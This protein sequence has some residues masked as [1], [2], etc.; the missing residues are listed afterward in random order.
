MGNSIINKEDALQGRLSSTHY[1]QTLLEALYTN[2]ILGDDDMQRIQLGLMNILNETIGYYTKD[3]SSSIREETAAQ[4]TASI[5]YT[6]GL[7]LKTQPDLKQAS[8][9]LQ[10]E[11]MKDLFAQGEEILRSKVRECR[12]LL[13]KAIQSRLK[14]GNLAYTDTLNYGIPLFF[15]EYDMRFASHETPGSIDY[16]LAIIKQDLAGVEYIEDYLNGLLLENEFCSFFEDKEIEA[17][18]RGYA[19]DSDLLLIN[20]FRLVLTNFLGYILAGKVGNSLEINEAERRDIKRQLDNLSDAEFEDIMK[21][22][23]E[24]IFQQL[25]IEDKDLKGYIDRTVGMITKEIRRHIERDTLKNLFITLKWPDSKRVKFEDG[26]SLKDSFFR[27]IT[28][29]IRD[30]SSVEDKIEIIKQELHSMR[31]LIDVFEADCIFADQFDDIFS[32]LGDFEI[33]LLM[34]HVSS[35][36]DW[37]NEDEENE[38]EWQT[39]FRMYFDTLGEERRNQIIRISEEIEI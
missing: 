16:P 17:L 26:E 27:D 29:E 15:K 3:E 14:T 32:V 34:K 2:N 38:K 6:I 39:E 12:M 9:M 5:Y 11:D 21:T 8:S 18:L 37:D 30:C 10:E 19:K 20:V 23:K 31:D 28:D 13:E 33:A 7:S 22:A 25:D 4:I 36:V 35:E 1:F 24:K